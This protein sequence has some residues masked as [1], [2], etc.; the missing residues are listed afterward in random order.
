MK[1]FGIFLVVIGI[2]WALVAFNMDT[3]VTTGSQ[4]YGSGEYAIDV[5][6]MAVNNLGLMETR[7][8]NLM[9]AGFT[10]LI[11]VLLIGFGSNPKKEVAAIGLKACPLCAEQIQPTAIKCRYCSSHLP[12]SFRASA[13]SAVVVPPSES[14]RLQSH[15]RL[16]EHGVP[17]IDTY[18]DVAS[19]LGGSLTSNGF[20]TGQHYIVDLGGIKSRVDKFEDLRQCFLDN[21]VSR[22]SA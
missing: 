7:R 18:M 1:S 5:P 6:S 9:F 16:I 21:A 11:G 12:D 2:I 8:N 15:F 20:L 19:I 14:E 13:V 10:I 3:T 22:E 4:R 17:S